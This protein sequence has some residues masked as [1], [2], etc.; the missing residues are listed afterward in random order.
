[1][2]RTQIFAPIAALVAAFTLAACSGDGPTSA[3]RGGNILRGVALSED[4]SASSNG[5]VSAM[6]KSKGTVTVTVLE[7]PTV[8]TTISGNGSFTLTN[9]PVGTFTLVFTDEAGVELGR[10]TISGVTDS[11]EVELVVQ[12]KKN[13]LILV[14]L[15]IEDDEDGD[16]AEKT[17]IINGGKVGTGIQLEGTADSGDAAAFVMTVNGNRASAP[18]NVDA[19]A[20]EFKCSGKGK[21]PEGTECSSLLTAGTKVHV[22]GTLLTCDLSTAQVIATKVQIKKT[23]DDTDGDDEGE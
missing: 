14:K 13:G 12:F 9:V 8:T 5:D 10:V 18:V 4:A 22:S 23:G 1:M 7:D 17:C 15:V 6:A 16:D 21:A 11:A 2:R 3:S 19:T 20:A